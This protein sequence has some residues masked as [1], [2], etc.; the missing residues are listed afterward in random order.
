MEGEETTDDVRK[1]MKCKKQKKESDGYSKMG[2][3][4]FCCKDCCEDPA[5]KKK[6]GEGGTCEFC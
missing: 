6:E 5:E 2:G 4:F 3:V 1:C